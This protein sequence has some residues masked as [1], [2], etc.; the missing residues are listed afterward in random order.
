ML[1]SKCKTSGISL[2]KT[3]KKFRKL[4]RKKKRFSLKKDKLRRSYRKRLNLLTTLTKIKKRR[5]MKKKRWMM[6]SKLNLNLTEE[7]FS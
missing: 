6:I 4:P 1:F 2:K 3:R 7:S 5:S